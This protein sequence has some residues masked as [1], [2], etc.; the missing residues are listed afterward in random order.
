AEERQGSGDLLKAVPVC[1][2]VQGGTPTVAAAGSGEAV[3]SATQD[4]AS[5]TASLPVDQAAR[6]Q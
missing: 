3:L 5:L 4:H 6:V 1:R 2:D